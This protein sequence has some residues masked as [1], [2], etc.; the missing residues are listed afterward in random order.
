MKKWFFVQSLVLLGGT[1]FAWYTISI[2]YRRFYDIEGTIFKVVDCRFPNPVTTPCFYGAWAF[3][4]AFIWS[5]AV[6][7]KKEEAAQK[8]QEKYLVWF[9]VAGTLFAWGNFAYG[10]FKFVA[11]QGKPV[12]GCSGQLVGDP[13]G[14]PCFYG[15]VLFLLSLASGSYLLWRLSK[16]QKLS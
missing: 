3:L 8:R 14:T 1:V 2:D 7:R 11:N 15:A 4:I 10:F 5:I 9:L 16:K 13:F 12:I 6:I